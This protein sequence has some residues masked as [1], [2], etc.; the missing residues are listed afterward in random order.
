MTIFRKLY[1][2]D[3]NSSIALCLNNIGN[4]YGYF[5]DRTIASDFYAKSLAIYQ[6]IPKNDQKQKLY[7][8]CRKQWVVF[9]PVLEPE[10]AK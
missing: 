9:K 4:V 3:D 2:N 5:S 7:K 6:K 10:P 1:A 8:N